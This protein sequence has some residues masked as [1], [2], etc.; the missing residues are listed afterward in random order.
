[1]EHLL[2]RHTLILA[3]GLSLLMATDLWLFLLALS[4]KLPFILPTLLSL[5]LFLSTRSILYFMRTI[6][7]LFKD[8]T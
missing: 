8:A 1:M 6:E 2:K 5:G 7:D 3:V 4:G